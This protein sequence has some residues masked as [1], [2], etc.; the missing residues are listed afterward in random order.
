[1]N[2]GELLDF[3]SYWARRNGKKKKKKSVMTI[4]ITRWMVADEIETI[5]DRA[6]YIMVVNENRIERKN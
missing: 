5:L 2:K 3:C 4:S 6:I 1:M